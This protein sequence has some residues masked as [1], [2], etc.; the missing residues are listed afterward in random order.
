MR[1]KVH[2]TVTFKVTCIV[3]K[4]LTIPLTSKINDVNFFKL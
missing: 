3:I 1:K 2:P 4:R